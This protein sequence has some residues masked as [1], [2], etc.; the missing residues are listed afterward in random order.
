[1]GRVAAGPAQGL[2]YRF[3]QLFGGERLE[4]GD[5]G[6]KRWVFSHIYRFNSAR[7]HDDRQRDLREPQL[8]DQFEP[9]H[10][11]HPVVGYQQVITAGLN[12]LPGGFTALDGGHLVTA[13][14]QHRSAE[15]KNGALVLNQED[16]VGET[17]RRGSGSGWRGGKEIDP[18]CFGGAFQ[19][20][21]TRR[22]RCVRIIR[23][24]EQSGQGGDGPAVLAEPPLD[25]VL[26]RRR[27]FTLTGG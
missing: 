6:L 11:W 14:N 9:R 3:Q 25:P 12:G 17:G 2:G 20:L 7:G 21:E 18:G 13:A 10:S 26:R 22:V 23:R 5:G 16:V 19:E 24:A 15:L 27:Q 4:Q 8:A 1:M